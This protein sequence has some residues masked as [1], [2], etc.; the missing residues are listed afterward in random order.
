MAR[1]NVLYPV[2]WV[3]TN[4]VWVKMAILVMSVWLVFAVIGFIKTEYNWYP[5]QTYPV[6]KMDDGP[7]D[8]MFVRTSVPEYGFLDTGEDLCEPLACYEHNCSDG[9]C[10]FSRSYC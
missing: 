5:S 10:I 3:K 4:I 1:R 2:I 8:N 6:T 7:P 9:E